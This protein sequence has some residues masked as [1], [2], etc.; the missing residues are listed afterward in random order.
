MTRFAMFIFITS[1]RQNERHYRYI[2][3]P[4]VLI[5]GMLHVNS[6]HRI[7]YI[8]GLYSSTV[9]REM[10]LI[11]SKWSPVG[12]VWHFKNSKS[13]LFYDI[14][15][16]SPLKV[17]GRF[18]GTCRHRVQGRRISQELVPTKLFDFQRPTRRYIS[19]DKTLH[20]HRCEGLKIFLR[21]FL[22]KSVKIL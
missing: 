3:E 16:C 4:L 12:F 22:Q 15:P 18:G 14:T 20:N 2:S 21:T 9:R 8:R 19:E 13:Y 7:C 1:W 5:H 11:C 10:Y 6:A 17:N